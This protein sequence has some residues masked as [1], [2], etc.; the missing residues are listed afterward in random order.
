MTVDRGS[1]AGPPRLRALSGPHS[2]SLADVLERVLDKGVVIVGDVV[3]SVLDV[4]LLTLKLRLFI[5]SA[6]TAREMGLDWWT[7][8]PFY[9]REARSLQQEQER[10]LQDE[11]MQALH[12]E[13]EELRARLA[14]LESSVR[15]GLPYRDEVAVESRANPP[16]G[17]PAE[18]ALPAEP[19]LRRDGPRPFWV[20]DS[21]RRH[22]ARRPDARR[23]DGRRLDGRRRD[24]GPGGR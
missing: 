24:G 22:D 9:S 11:T 6:D 14:T 15:E 5:A 18:A 17:I 7:T 3:I 1:L 2:D 19:G 20:Q 21:E 8:D 4:E 13:N 23:L 12:A 10:E 16:T